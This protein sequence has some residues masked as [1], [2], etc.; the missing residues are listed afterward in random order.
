MRGWRCT[1]RVP[2]LPITPPIIAPAVA[3]VCDLLYLVAAWAIAGGVGYPLDDS[4]IHQTLARNLVAFGQFAINPGEPVTASTAPLWTSIVAVGYALGLPPLLWTYV[5]G[6]TCLAFIAWE[7]WLLGKALLPQGSV[8]PQLAGLLVLVEWHLVW[9]A[10]SGMETLLFTAL[11]LAALQQAAQHGTR[12]PCPF[13]KRAWLLGALVGLATLTR[14]EGLLLGL[15]LGCWI[16]FAAGGNRWRAPVVFIVTLAAVLLPAALLNLALSGRPLPATFYAKNAAYATAPGLLPFAQYLEGAALALARGPLFLVYPGLLYGLL[17]RFP[18]MPIV[19]L[20]P[21]LWAALLITAYMVWLPAL[22]H[23]GRYLF[24][25]IPLIGL[26]GLEGSRLLLSKLPYRLLPRFAGMLLVVAV[27]A[28]WAR[29]AQ[30]YGQNVDTIMQQQVQ[31]ALWIR[32]H[33]PE[34][35]VVA[36]HDIGALGYYSQ[37]RLVDVAGLANPELV[38]SPKDVDRIVEVLLDRHVSYLALLP[39]WYPP[40]YDRLTGDLRIE[41]VWRGRGPDETQEGDAT[42]E[43]LRLMPN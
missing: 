31:A 34:D 35:A 37:R 38:N 24:P 21:L 39:G 36:T 19:W 8:V 15:A 6:L 12:R 11:S 20:L 40:L 14:P 33:T 22:Y 26:Y 5:I 3:L 13:G 29:G 2:I 25:L 42:F 30:V 10:F 7:T 43:V 28:S 1:S 23:H 32:E 18:K 27:V 41:L 16:L 4:W 9:A 17:R